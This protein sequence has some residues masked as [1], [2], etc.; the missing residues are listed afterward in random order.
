MG[1]NLCLFARGPILSNAIWIKLKRFL[2]ILD[3][4]NDIC[5]FR[6]TFLLNGISGNIGNVIQ[7]LGKVFVV[8]WFIA[9]Y[10]FS[11]L[12]LIKI[13]VSK[14]WKMWAL[15]LLLIWILSIIGCAVV[16]NNPPNFM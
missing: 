14:R 4:C 6:D 9:Y 7:S 8:G 2:G 10:V 1:F 3:F 13:Q 16:T 15:I 11:I 12:A 5:A